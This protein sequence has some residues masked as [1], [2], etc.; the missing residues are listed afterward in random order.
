M[1][2]FR[3]EKGYIVVRNNKKSYKIVGFSISLGNQFC[4]L[5]SYSLLLLISLQIFYIF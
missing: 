1:L 5:L 2:F 4:K 3:L